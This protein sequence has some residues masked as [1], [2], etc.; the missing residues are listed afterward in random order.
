MSN[1]PDGQPERKT[2]SKA[3]AARE[4]RTMAPMKDGIVMATVTSHPAAVTMA[5]AINGP[6]TVHPVGQERWA[7]VRLPGQLLA[8]A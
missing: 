3:Y 6:T 4:D 7:V 2:E 8:A 5:R 1:A